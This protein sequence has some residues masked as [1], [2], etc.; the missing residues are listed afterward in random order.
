M[1]ELN[2]LTGKILMRIWDIDSGYLN[3]Q[4]LLGEH[5]ELHGIASIIITNNKMGYSKHPEILRW[6]E[7]GW[8]L[9]QHHRQITAEMALR[10]LNEKS[11][12]ELSTNIRRWPE[13]SIDKPHQQYQLLKQKDLEKSLVVFHYPIAP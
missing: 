10:G 13:G 1:V 4:N 12:V 5:M 8:A 11:P 2:Q 9:S 3:N 7:F 6:K